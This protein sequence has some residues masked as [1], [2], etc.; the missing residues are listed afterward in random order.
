MGHSQVPCRQSL[1]LERGDR[2]DHDLGS[3]DSDLVEHATI[4]RQHRL[5]VLE[6]TEE[7]D[8]AGHQATAS[9]RRAS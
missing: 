5:V 6:T 9:R 7:T 4:D 1:A 2:E 8:R 3:E